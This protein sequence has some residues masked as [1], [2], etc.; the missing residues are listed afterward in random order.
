L[1]LLVLL[2][3][4]YVHGLILVVYSVLNI[5][6]NGSKITKNHQKFK[7]FKILNFCCIFLF[8]NNFI[9]LYSILCVNLGDIVYI[10]S[11]N[12]YLVF[13]NY[14]YYIQKNSEK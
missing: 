11:Y 4:L 9:I 7:I 1:I 10:R 3:L 12:E 8:L 5:V 14:Y 6:I 13:S 2:C